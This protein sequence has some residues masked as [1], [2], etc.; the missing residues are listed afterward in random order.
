MSISSPTPEDV[1]AP[2]RFAEAVARM[3]RRSRLIHF[4][5]KALPVA[6]IA[7]S[8]VLSGFMVAKTILRLLS[9]LTQSTEIHMTNPH[10]YGQYG[11]DEEH[12]RSF[13]IAASEARR[14][15]RLSTD[16]KLTNPDVKLAGTGDR[17]MRI[18]A[19]SGVYDEA[20]KRVTLQ[21]DVTVVSGDGTTFHT[22][23]ALVDTHARSVVGNSF[24]Q[25]SG[26][27]GQIQASSYAITNNGAE[28][29]FTGQVH[30]HL[31]PR[32]D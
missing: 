3:R 12:R 6:I 4:L 23:Q 24:V 5:R 26:P 10:F 18:T 2:P 16:V 9:D 20:T 8:L 21:G 11:K 14:S 15:L 28:A 32:R 30:A 25:G 22:Q 7:L 1:L 13:E 19:R 31:T 29:V 27:L 17:S